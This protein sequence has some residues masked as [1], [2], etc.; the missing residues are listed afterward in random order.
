LPVAPARSPQTTVTLTYA[1]DGS[2]IGKES[3]TILD[4][5]ANVLASCT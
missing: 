4:G 2:A 5:G 1:S 3:L